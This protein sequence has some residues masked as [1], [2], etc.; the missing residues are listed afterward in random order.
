MANC[1]GELY[2]QKFPV[3]S[4]VISEFVAETGSQQTACTAI[5]VMLAVAGRHLST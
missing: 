5:R 3:F 1:S 2:L 4:H